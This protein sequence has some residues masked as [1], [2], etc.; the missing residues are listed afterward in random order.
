MVLF[1]FKRARTRV[2]RWSCRTSNE[3]GTVSMHTGTC[4]RMTPVLARVF[5]GSFHSTSLSAL[6]SKIFMLKLK[7]SRRRPPF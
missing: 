4:T 5:R 7:G 3:N 6:R 1:K 2:I